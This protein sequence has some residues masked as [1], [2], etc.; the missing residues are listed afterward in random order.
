[1]ELVSLTEIESTIHEYPNYSRKLEL[2]KSKEKIP[3][4]SND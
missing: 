3:S 2:F 4:L 1:M